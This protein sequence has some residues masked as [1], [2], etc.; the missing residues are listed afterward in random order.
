MLKVGLT[1]G[2]ASGKSFVAGLLAEHG[3]HVIHAD[4]LGH[5][6]LLPD[7]EVYPAVV[8]E[9]GC[10]IL[11]ADGEIDRKLLGKLVFSDPERLEVLNSLVHPYV[12]RRQEEF[13][14][15]VAGED[16]AGIAVVEA[17]IMIEVGSY[18]RYDRL[19]ITYCSVEQQ[20]ERFVERE[21]GSEEEARARLARQMPLEAKRKFADYIID[22]SGSKQDTARG[23]EQVYRKL[24]AEA[25][26]AAIV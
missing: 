4:R 22:T 11:R 15:A 23:V 16:P 6:A 5:E 17:A 14:A 26:A 8:Q 24:H 20:V 7:G 13:F 19:V 1:G 18:K 10:D 9:F 21:G 12:F 3:C 2:L 25:R